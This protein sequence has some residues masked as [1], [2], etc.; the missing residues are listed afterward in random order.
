MPRG[1]VQQ[2]NT[3]LPFEIGDVLAGHRRG[4]IQPLG[5]FDKAAGFDNI[6]EYS[7]TG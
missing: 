2:A 5:G 3:Q 1:P 6:A 7:Q 4:D